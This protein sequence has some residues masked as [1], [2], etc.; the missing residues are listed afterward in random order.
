MLGRGAAA[1][2]SPTPTRRGGGSAAP[3]L[4]LLLRQRRLAMQAAEAQQQCAAPTAAPAVATSSQRQSPSYCLFRNGAP[5]ECAL[6]A[7]AWLEAAPRGAYTTARTVGPEGDRVLKLASHI[8]RLALSANLMAAADAQT[9]TAASA[10]ADATSSG[11]GDGGGDGGGAAAPAPQQQQPLFSA[12]QLRPHVVAC[13]GAAIAAFRRGDC[14]GG[15]GSGGGG[16]SGT[17]GSGEQEARQLKLT[18]LLTW[19]DAAGAGGRANQGGAG[20]GAPPPFD[21]W[22]HGEPLPPRPRPPVRVEVRGLPRSNA[23]AKDSE[24]VRRRRALEASKPAD[25]NEVV[26]SS[27]DGRLMEGLSSNFFAVLDGAVVTA[28]EGV[29]SGTIREIVLEASA[30]LGGLGCRDVAGAAA[31]KQP[32]LVVMFQQPDGRGKQS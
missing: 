4:P 12:E 22:C 1:A 3:L 14:G 21:L 17:N 5:V 6:P 32:P 2:P 9:V 7:G 24:W 28:D 29:L 11:D 15:S 27:P 26:L 16:G 18:M 25:A 23:R 8:E 30:R 20:E 19:G 31:I 10:A 13:L